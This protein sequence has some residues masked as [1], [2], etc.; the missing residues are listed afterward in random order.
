MYCTVCSFCG[1]VVGYIVHFK[2]HLCPIHTKTPDAIW[3]L[4]S[5]GLSDCRFSDGSML[6]SFTQTDV[7]SRAFYLV[8][9]TNY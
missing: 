9:N 7:V 4:S 1:I 5:V 6:L 3:T 8:T 2:N